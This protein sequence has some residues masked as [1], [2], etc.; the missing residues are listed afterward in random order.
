[1]RKI[2]GGLAAA[3]LFGAVAAV[4][5][6]QGGGPDSADYVVRATLG[7]LSAPW[8]LLPFLAGSACRGLRGG[9]VTGLGT[10][11]VALVGFYTATGLII[12]LDGRNGLS[13]AP[14]WM[15]A[16]QV[17]FQAGLLTGP[18]LGALGAAWQRGSRHRGRGTTAQ[19]QGRVWWLAALLLAGEP[20]V[21]LA[22]GYASP[23]SEAWRHELPPLL[24][25]PLMWGLT[26]DRPAG[27]LI[28]YATELAA[29]L[30]LLAV[31][32]DRARRAGP[33]LA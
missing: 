33:R 1:M 28:V 6:D 4:V 30:T 26:L 7:N 5:K 8:L 21:L 17:H 32:V 12:G 18:L 29:G 2:A 9:A 14:L 15:L 10:T 23:L 24:G 31:L 19:G 11:L 13:A 25:L 27:T 16:N 3:A 22:L 20:L